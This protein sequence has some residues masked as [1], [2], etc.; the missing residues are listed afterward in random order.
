MT[1]PELRKANEEIGRFLLWESE[2]LQWFHRYAQKFGC[3][4]AANVFKFALEDA[5]RHRGLTLEQF[6]A[7]YR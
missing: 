1:I 3:D 7:E 2:T 4:P 5:L 6:M